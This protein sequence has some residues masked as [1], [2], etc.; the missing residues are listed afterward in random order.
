[1]TKHFL[2]HGMMMM[3]FFFFPG[4]LHRLIHISLLSSFA[5][6]QFYATVQYCVSQF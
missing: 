2:Q 4:L 1:M 5:P 3:H 6:Q